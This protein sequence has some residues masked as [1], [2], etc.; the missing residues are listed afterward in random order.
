MPNICQEVLI[1]ASA[2]EVYNAL[3]TQRGLQGWWTPDAKAE[4]KRDSIARFPFGPNYFKEMKITELE[5]DKKVRWT[6]VHG[7][8]EWIGTVLSF[9]LHAGDKRWLL[10]SRYELGGQIQQ[11]KHE[12]GT[13][14]VF[15]HNDWKA[16]TPMFAE[17]S[18]TWGQFLRSLKLLCETGKG[19]PFPYQHAAE[20]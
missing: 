20:V 11:S 13:L 18:Y 8:D 12:S 4:A 6:C 9:E 15:S 10:S 19:R 17:C 2:G 16:Y 14:V 7:V 3:T 5:P 1:G